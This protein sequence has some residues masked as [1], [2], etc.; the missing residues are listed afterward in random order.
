MHDELGPIVP[1]NSVVHV[2]EL[3]RQVEQSNLVTGIAMP[4]QSLLHVGLRDR[5]TMTEELVRENLQ[6]SPVDE[7]NDRD[8]SAAREVY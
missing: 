1:N 7:T 2:F 6:L 4:K 8:Y 5:P 3:E